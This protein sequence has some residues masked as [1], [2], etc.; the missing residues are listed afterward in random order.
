MIG[1]QIV[2]AVGAKTVETVGSYAGFAAV[3]GLGVLSLLYFSQA[4]EVKRLREWAGR[5]PERALELEQRV[6]ADAQRRVVA[7]PLAPPSAAAQTAAAARQ[8][9]AAAELYAKLPPP[10][11]PPA[12]LIGPP[13]Q[14]AR[15][16]TPAAT[17]SPATAAGV[18]AP[19][20]GSAPTATPTPTPAPGSPAPAVLPGATAGAAGSAPSPSASAPTSSP[21]TAAAA[22]AAAARQA[23]ASSRAV[24]PP[25]T[26]NGAG[27]ETH[28]SDAARPSP[29]PVLPEAPASG[30]DEGRGFSVVRIVAI[31]GGAVAVVLIA[32][33]LMISLTGDDPK[34]TPN[35]FGTSTPAAATPSDTSAGP[36]STPSSNGSTA[37][38]DRK[39]IKIAVLNGT[40]QTGLARGVADKLGE[41]G[42]TIGTV[43]NNTD[44]QVPQT[45]VSYS[46]GNERA[47]QTVAELIKVDRSS[48]QSIDANTS[49]ATDADVV[50][51]V[52]TNQIG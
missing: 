38:V 25:P 31:V 24:S 42:F 1:V 50:V 34:P 10:P 35:D 46:P 37:R 19:A 2:A 12:P 15:P 45:T 32:V 6:Q 29:L 18:T 47:A 52:G 7:E 22:A 51:T 26:S 43:G 44:Q 3:V 28:E 27:Q 49:V 20:V 40:R 41:S 23:A 9:A 5:A 11:P 14:L 17:A 21:A 13:G 48:V 33:V 8:T 39:S 30:S 4:R 36:S 16:A